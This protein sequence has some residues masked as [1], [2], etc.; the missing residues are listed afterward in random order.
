[1]YQRPVSILQANSGSVHL[2]LAAED[3]LLG[4]M[5]CWL[6]IR[7][8]PKLYQLFRSL[9]IARFEAKTRS[10]G[11]T[12]SKTH[13]SGLNTSSL[14]CP[15]SKLPDMWTHMWPCARCCNCVILR[16]SLSCRVPYCCSLLLHW[17]SPEY[18]NATHCDMPSKYT[19]QHMYQRE[20]L[21]E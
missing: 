9:A 15:P 17:I 7:E 12:Y 4:S 16:C 8:T 6:G 10:F 19:L 2:S 14:L 5:R 13:L 11:A 1:M 20:L 21:L 18:R 3:T